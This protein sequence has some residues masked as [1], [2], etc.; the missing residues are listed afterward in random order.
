MR[1][2][3]SVVTNVRSTHLDPGGGVKK[4]ILTDLATFKATS[5]DTSGAYTLY[6][7]ETPP[8]G[9]FPPHV[10]RYEDETF[11]VLESSYDFL[12]VDNELRLDAGAYLFVPR[13]TIHGYVNTGSTPARMLVLA[14]PGGVHEKFLD[15]IADAAE[16]PAWKPDI[17]K[18]LAVAPK[19]G[20][21]F[22][23]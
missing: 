22:L 8:S 14:T 19:Y 4:R 2:Q 10:H 16:R 5:A 1:F 12:L 23:A 18:V 20:I 6:E 17:A 7:V 11:F 15:E 21:D 13:G 3:M 9:G